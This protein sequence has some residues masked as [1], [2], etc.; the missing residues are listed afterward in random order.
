M[1]M[2]ID[3]DIE[4]IQ[5]ALYDFSISTGVSIDLLKEDF[6]PVVQNRVTFKGYC[7]Q[8]QSTQKGK[9][10]C[11]ASDEILLKR[12]RES[13]KTEIH[14][15]QAGLI[16]VVSPIIYADKIAGYII[17]GQIRGDLDF[18]VL[19]EYIEEL[20]LDNAEMKQLFHNTVFCDAERIE[21][22]CNVAAM[23]IS[24][25]LFKKMVKPNIDEGLQR[26]INYIV[27]NIQRDISVN[28]ISRATGLSK[29]ALYKKF[30]HA[31]GCTVGEYI[32]R[33]RV[34]C[35]AVLIKSTNLSMEEIS[36]KAGFTS[37]SYFSR[38]FK[39]I[40]GVSPVQFKKTP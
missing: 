37:A 17:F 32:N 33:K 10:A 28:S 38:T 18:S 13:Q 5:K 16:N 15:C 39:R 14:F 21:C 2:I 12:C 40:K 29:S 22:L 26:V 4:K 6:T 23:L 35:A 8:I 36:Q 24:Y 34:E 7:S 11:Q 19:R 31:L 27:E 3:Y 1:G 25:I 20:G 9:I 30:H